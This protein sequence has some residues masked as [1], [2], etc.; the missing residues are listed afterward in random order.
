MSATRRFWRKFTGFLHFRLAAGAAEV[1]RSPSVDPRPRRRKRPN[2]VPK[3]CLVAMA[4]VRN[5]DFIF[6]PTYDR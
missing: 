5:G 1:R 2:P 4:T 6:D 3:S